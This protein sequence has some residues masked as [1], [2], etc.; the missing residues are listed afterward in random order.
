MSTT[1]SSTA[2]PVVQEDAGLSRSGS[3]L[4]PAAAVVHGNNDVM[5]S[6]KDEIIEDTDK[7]KTV[8][9]EGEADGALSM[10]DGESLLKPGQKRTATGDIKYEAN[11]INGAASG[12]IER[13]RT[14]GSELHG[15]DKI[16]EVKAFSPLFTFGAERFL[17]FII[18]MYSYL[19]IC[20]HVFRMPP[21]R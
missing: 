2:S 6:K 3:Q 7:F 13:S 9:G 16:A 8:Q 5:L 1:E 4:A 12:R 11:D 18:S 19:L 20:E 17:T 21:L 10:I 15:S 14:M